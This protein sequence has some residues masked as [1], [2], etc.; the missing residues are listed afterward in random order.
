MQK[1][2]KIYDRDSHLTTCEAMVLHCEF[3][4]A[5]DTHAVILDQTVFFP[6]GGGQ[7]ADLGYICENASEA[8][9]NNHKINQEPQKPVIL[10]NILD[11][12]ISD[13]II[14]HY[15]DRPL[16][17]GTRV[18]CH[19]DWNRRFDFMQQHSA[20]HILSGLVYRTF[21]YHNV[22]FHLGMTETTLDFDGPLTLEQLTWLEEEANKAI[23]QNIAFEITFPNKDTLTNLDYR[24]KKELSGEVRIVT[25]PGYDICACCAPHVYHTGEI[26]LVKIVSSM[27][28]RG[29]MRLTILC[30]GRALWD[31][32]TKQTS[33]EQ[34]SA[35]LSAKQPEVAAAVAKAK[36]DQ[37]A[38]IYRVNDLQKKV[39]EAELKS[40]PA[41]DTTENVF[42]FQKDLDTKAIRNAVNDLCTRYTGYCGIF[43]GDSET[44]YNFVLGS[45]TKDCREAAT[46]L[47]EAF[48]AKGGGS[49][50]MIQGS[51]TANETAIRGLIQ[52]HS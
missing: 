24:S 35:L 18:T 12:Q 8:E 14:T 23:W 6:E 9:S 39:L 43:V 27:V 5:R 17:V 19:I 34:I 4:K 38:L 15:T 11:V 29:G 47:R 26:G 7:F 32:Q 25:L 45:A 2:I 46:A 50:K 21:G 31:Y 40:L 30:G 48:G 16:E 1:T 51:V 36:E 22:G 44:G 33:V 10:A 49:A 28:H 42:L 13:D 3:D 20:E 41:P 37:Q 52:R